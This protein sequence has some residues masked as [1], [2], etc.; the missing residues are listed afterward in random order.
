MTRTIAADQAAMA[1]LSELRGTTYDSAAS[2]C[3][4]ERKTFQICSTTVSVE[5]AGR[6]PPGFLNALEHCAVARDGA[7]DL[8]IQ[9]LD[10]TT[11]G[12]QIPQMPW[13][14]EDIRELGFVRGFNSERFYT[15]FN[16]YSMLLAMADLADGLGF[17]WHRAMDEIAFFEGSSPL[18]QIISPWFSARRNT[19][20]VHSAVVG[21]EGA[22]VLLAGLGGSGKSTTAIACLNA[23]M[24]YL[25]DDYVMLSRNP[26][27]TAHSIYS[28]AKLHPDDLKRFSRLEQLFEGREALHDDKVMFYLAEVPEA[29]VVTSAEVRAVVVPVITGEKRSTCVPASPAA[30]LRALAPSTIFQ[31]W[32]SGRAQFGF[33]SDLVR[34]VPCYTLRA[35]TEIDEIPGVIL[36][37]LEKLDG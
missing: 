33:L 32:G 13:R 36:D 19:H 20:M 12:V 9:V 14:A 34:Q 10:S 30:A 25:A 26:R 21:A 4:Q 22:G 28:T 35:G 8:S 29:N 11:T 1:F 18:R 24:E 15:N 23:G 3:G 7:P 27:P 5:C 37:L 16:V 17:V 2:R 31:L 6:V